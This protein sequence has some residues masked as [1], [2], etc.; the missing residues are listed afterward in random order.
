M[1]WREYGSDGLTTTGDAIRFVLRFV[2]TA[3]RSHLRPSLLSPTLCAGR[4]N[5]RTTVAQHA[6]WLCTQPTR[7]VRAITRYRHATPQPHPHAT[8]NALKCARHSVASLSLHLATHARA[9]L[10]RVPSKQLLCVR[11]RPDRG[12]KRWDG[13]I[14]GFA[15]QMHPAQLTHSRLEN[16]QTNRV[17]PRRVPA[18]LFPPRPEEGLG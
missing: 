2:Y 3:S 7:A 6:P 18:P 14:G 4:H 12:H 16:V 9:H 5:T 15:R 10:H 8:H 11:S 17:A 13:D 1:C